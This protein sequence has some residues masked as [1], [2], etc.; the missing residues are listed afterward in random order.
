MVPWHQRFGEEKCRS[1]KQKL[2]GGSSVLVSKGLIRICSGD[3][4]SHPILS[5]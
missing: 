4:L 2:L 1:K 5:I 3:F